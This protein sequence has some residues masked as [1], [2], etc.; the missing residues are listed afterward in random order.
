MLFFVVEALG[1]IAW[2]IWT[3]GSIFEIFFLLLPLIVIASLRVLSFYH[4]P[5]I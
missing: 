1:P 4:L 3:P 2:L 5:E